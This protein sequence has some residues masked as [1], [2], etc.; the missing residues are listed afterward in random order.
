MHRDVVNASDAGVTV[1]VQ[2][3]AG[4]KRGGTGFD[5]DI[6]KSDEGESPWPCCDYQ[7][8]DGVRC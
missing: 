3:D 7:V 1:R 2:R 8:G 6:G 5:E 4:D